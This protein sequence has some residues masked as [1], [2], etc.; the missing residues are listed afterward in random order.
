MGM[1]LSENNSRLELNRRRFIHTA[2]AAS[3]AGMAG[4]VGLP[5]ERGLLAGVAKRQVTPPLHIPYLTSSGNGTC[6]PFASVHDNLFARA[7]VVD[8]GREAVAV[9]SVDAI[10][11]DDAVLGPGRNFTSELRKAVA[12]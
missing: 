8:S 10:G 3:L 6:A 12:G 2:G 11:Y 5:G 7:L 1:E 9:L 4:C